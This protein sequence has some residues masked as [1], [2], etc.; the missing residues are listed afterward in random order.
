ML[1]TAAQ[2]NTKVVLQLKHKKRNKQK[3][4]KIGR[5]VKIT[6]PGKV[7]KGSID[8][9]TDKNVYIGSNII[10]T[11]NIQKIR[12]RLRGTQVSGAIIGTV[13]LLTTG[14]GL[15]M[16]IVSLKSTG[17]GSGIAAAIGIVF[18]GSGVIITTGSAILFFVGKSYKSSKWKFD[19]VEIIK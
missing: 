3:Y 17:L 8:S 18:T 19:A 15:V 1:P 10:A 14:L 11:D 6:T 2:N 7:Y 9:L 13:G 4:I 16:L 5:R 12:F